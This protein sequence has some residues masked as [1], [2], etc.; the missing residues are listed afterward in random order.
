MGLAVVHGIVRNHGGQIHVDSRPGIGTTVRILLPAL[1]SGATGI[2]PPTAPT[3]TPGLQATDSLAGCRVLFVDDESAIA[4]FVARDLARRGLEVT[5]RTNPLEALALAAAQPHHFD[6][7]IS[8]LHM[9]KLSGLEL[10]ERVRESQP[11]ARR[12]L[13]SGMLEPPVSDVALAGGIDR[14]LGKPVSIDELIAA[15]EILLARP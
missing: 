14:V 2:S 12:I 3:A 11:G 5:T 13:I 9:P 6:V 1:E 10:L 8:D 4:D 15:L 7:V